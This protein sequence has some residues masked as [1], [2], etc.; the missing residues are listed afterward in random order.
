MDF[1]LGLATASAA[2]TS[3]AGT[4]TSLALTTWRTTALHLLIAILAGWSH[5]L[6]IGTRGRGR[7]VSLALNLVLT[8]RRGREVLFFLLGLSPNI[9]ACEEK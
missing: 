1:F 2:T 5:L 8:R 9:C 4:A 6:A 3:S 7:K